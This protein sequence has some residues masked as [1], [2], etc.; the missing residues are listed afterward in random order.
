MEE[1][2]FAEHAEETFAFSVDGQVYCIDFSSV[3]DPEAV[4]PLGPIDIEIVNLTAGILPATATAD[5]PTW[6]PDGSGIVFGAVLNAGT[7]SSEA[8]IAEIVF[9]T[10]NP[11]GCPDTPTASNSNFS[12]I[13]GGGTRWKSPRLAHPDYRRDIP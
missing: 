4:L 1:Y 3:N 5:G 11:M 12:V 9:D 7:T 6:R 13:A 8:V 10:P 2:D